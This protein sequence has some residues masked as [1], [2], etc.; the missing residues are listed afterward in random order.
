MG[1]LIKYTKTKNTGSEKRFS[2]KCLEIELKTRMS[3][4]NSTESIFAGQSQL[5]IL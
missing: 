1:L 5:L 2:R 4:I 3:L